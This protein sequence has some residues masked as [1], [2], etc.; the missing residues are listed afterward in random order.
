[1]LLML[2]GRY[3]G[4]GESA[5]AFSSLEATGLLNRSRFGRGISSRELEKCLYLW[6]R[7]LR[8]GYLPSKGQSETSEQVRHA[9]NEVKTQ[10]KYIFQGRGSAG[11]SAYCTSLTT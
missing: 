8:L 10:W 4:A 11:E 6:V 7:Q 5:T 1:M 9:F 2:I 3:S